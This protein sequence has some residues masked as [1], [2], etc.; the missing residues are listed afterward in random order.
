M[1]IYNNSKLTYSGVLDREE[2]RTM[3]SDLVK[4]KM[5]T[6]SFDDCLKDFDQ[7]Q[8]AEISFNEYLEWFVRKGMCLF[9]LKRNETYAS[10]FFVSFLK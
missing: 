5:T 7:N 3:H 6:L 2:F 1:T 10:L 4:N 8:T 9:V